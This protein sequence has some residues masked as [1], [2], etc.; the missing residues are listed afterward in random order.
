[1]QLWQMD[2]MSGVLLADGRSLKLV[3]GL[4]DHSRFC[5]IAKLVPRETGRS[6][7]LALAEALREFGV[8]Q[9]IL[10]DNG[11]QF[12]GAYARPRPHEVLFERILRENGIRHR[13]TPVRT[14]TTTGK[15]ERIHLTIQR[16]LL[17]DA[18]PFA[19]AASAQ[20]AVDRWR[21][22]YNHERPHQSLDMAT[23]ASR[24]RPVTAEERAALPLVLPAQL[25][26][27][28]PGADMAP[29]SP[30]SCP[31]PRPDRGAPSI[32]EGGLGPSEAVEPTHRTVEAH[33]AASAEAVE[34]ERMVPRSG[35]LGVCGQQFWLGEALGDKLVTL[36]IDTTSVHLTVE[37]RRVKTVVS[38]ITTADLARLRAGGARPAG[39][40]PAPTSAGGVR[41]GAAIEVDRT[42]NASGTVSIG[43]IVVGIGQILGGRRVTLRLDGEVIHVVADGVLAKTIPNPLTPQKR[44][45]VPGA[46]LAGVPPRIHTGPVRVQRTVSHSGAIQV[47]KQK[48]QVGLR[49][50]RTIVSVEVDER[51]LKVLND[52]GEVLKEVPR[53]TQEEVTRFKAWGSWSRPA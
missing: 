28:T 27:V 18:M 32:L 9:E 15:V 12:T 36:W 10:T 29:D 33:V 49:Y 39:P 45:K 3:S 34:I 17:N 44:L 22:G 52:A 8:P 35:N 38:R 5:V 11:V 30:Y 19:D 40:P 20:A 23:P 41:Y 1:M 31:D 25:R 47:A 48:V 43:G 14:P 53:T 46:R 7:C 24:F 16:E 42:V 4:D 51:T 26:A 6:V 13:R 2:I 50:A 21:Q 37:G